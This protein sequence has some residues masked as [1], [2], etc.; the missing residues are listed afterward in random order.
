MYMARG[1][2]TFQNISLKWIRS[3]SF[4]T[5][6]YSPARAKE[7]QYVSYY[8]LHW[9]TWDLW[10]LQRES[11]KKFWFF[12]PRIQILVLYWLEISL[13]TYLSVKTRTNL[14]STPT[15]PLIFFGNWLASL[16]TACEFLRMYNEKELQGKNK[17][18]DCKGFFLNI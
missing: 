17:C 2:Q 3:S 18:T 9:A 4:I 10:N 1:S 6:F 7:E 5:S 16:L 14:V 11:G 15:S 13:S 8:Y 12:K